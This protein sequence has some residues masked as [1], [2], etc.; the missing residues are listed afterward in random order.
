[1]AIWWATVTNHF[2][3]FREKLGTVTMLLYSTGTRNHKWQW[4]QEGL[5]NEHLAHYSSHLTQWTHCQTFLI[6]WSKVRHIMKRKRYNLLWAFI[7]YIHFKYPLYTQSH[8]YENFCVFIQNI[9][10]TMQHHTQEFEI[11]WLKRVWP[12]G[13]TSL[14]INIFDFCVSIW[15]LINANQN[16]S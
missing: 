3:F 4:P 2:T 14:K 7:N 12:L 16:E 15:T 8:S 9:S 10:Y 13:E 11:L 5:N 6:C 1:M